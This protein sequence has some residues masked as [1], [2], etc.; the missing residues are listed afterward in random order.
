MPI[1]ASF[2]LWYATQ[3]LSGEIANHLLLDALA[4]TGRPIVLSS[5]MSPLEELGGMFDT[6][7]GAG[8][9]DVGVT[10]LC[11]GG[12]NAGAAC[13]EDEECSWEEAVHETFTCLKNSAGEG[14]EEE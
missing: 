9:C 7:L 14:E 6:A 13:A 2:A 12:P 11:V 3:E 10:D 5:G 8:T 4:E 1:D